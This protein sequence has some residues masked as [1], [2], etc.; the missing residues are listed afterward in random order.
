MTD[1]DAAADARPSTPRPAHSLADLPIQQ[2][3]PLAPVVV[4]HAFTLRSNVCA[5]WPLISDTD[6]LNRLAGMRRVQ[7]EPLVDDSAARYRVRAWI[8]GFPMVYEELPGQ[9]IENERYAIRRRVLNGPLRALEMRFQLTPTADGGTRVTYSLILEPRWRL[10]VPVARFNGHKRLRRFERELRR[11]D[12]SLAAGQPLG[13]TERKYEADPLALERSSQA[14]QEMLAPDLHPIAEQVVEVVRQGADFD[15][16]RLRP[17]VLADEW[18]RD[19]HDVLAVCLTAV[20]AGL[21]ELSWE[22]IC[23]SCRTAAGA[24]TTLADVPTEGHCHL[25]DLAYGI[26]LDKA[27][28]VTFRPAPAVRQ[29][30]GGPYCVGGPARTPHVV[31]QAVVAPGTVV[32]VPVPEGPGRYRLFVRGGASGR[33]EAVGGAPATV[34]TGLS[35]IA[36]AELMVAPGG[37][38]RITG[39]GDGAC[40]VKLE[41]VQWASQAATAHHVSLTPTFRKLFSQEALKPGVSLRI[42]RVALLFSDLTASTALYSKAGDAYAFRLVLEHFDLLQ[43]IIEGRGGVIVKT[44]GDAIMAAFYDDG[45]ALQAAVEMQTAFAGFVAQHAHAV[46]VTLKLGVFAGPCYAVTANG[47][48]DYFGQTVNIA[49]RLQGQAES[50]EIVV[51]DSLASDGAAA[52]WLT[53]ATVVE[54]FVA[55]LKGVS[56]PIPCARVVARPA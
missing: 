42:S 32:T 2:E 39:D 24:A 10:I 17:F 51:P 56:T 14:L 29:V 41:H 18:G 28:E 8:D 44:I 20:I 11:L 47:A 46:D 40:H 27:V 31:A 50:G 49:A 7:L 5:L 25:C 54:T 30:D 52:G 34:S 9:W 15:V 53:G 37:Q 22:L 23:P 33:V 38:L 45:A 19:R 35:A 16:S 3:G 13:S 55:D 4:T 21:V 1:M 26:D 43:A 36:G 6:R 48:L 12:D